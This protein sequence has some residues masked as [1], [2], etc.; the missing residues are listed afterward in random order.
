MSIK[1]ISDWKLIIE[2][3]KFLSFEKNL[4][5]DIETITQSGGSSWTTRISKQ[6]CRS[7]ELRNGET[8]IIAKPLGFYNNSVMVIDNIIKIEVKDSVGMVYGITNLPENMVVNF[9]GK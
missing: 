4:I 1:D 2:L 3:I 7:V 5:V 6:T 8:E 9:K